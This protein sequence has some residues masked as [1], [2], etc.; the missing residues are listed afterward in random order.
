MKSEGID[1]RP[2]ITLDQSPEP[3]QEVNQ[4][5]FED[6]KVPKENLLPNHSG[7]SAPLGCLDSARYGIAWGALGAAMECYDVAK[8]Y[9]DWFD[10]DPVSSIIGRQINEIPKF[11]LNGEFNGY[12]PDFVY[13]YRKISNLRF[14]EL[15]ALSFHYISHALKFTN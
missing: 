5:F 13:R 10:F 11:E 2:L 9:A 12:N 7:L 8:K 3:Y 4:V 1:V 14:F 15:E 6:V